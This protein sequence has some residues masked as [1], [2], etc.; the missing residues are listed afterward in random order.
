MKSLSFDAQICSHVLSDENT[1]YE[2]KSGQRM[3]GVREVDEVLL[4]HEMSKRKR[5]SDKNFW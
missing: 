2:A 5:N 1:G 3:G 4:V